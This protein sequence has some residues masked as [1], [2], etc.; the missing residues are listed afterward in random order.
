MEKQDG[1]KITYKS[2]HRRPASEPVQLEQCFV[3]GFRYKFQTAQDGWG[4]VDARQL[5]CRE[6]GNDIIRRWDGWWSERKKEIETKQL[7]SFIA[8]ME[9][10][11]MYWEKLLMEIITAQRA[12][13]PFGL[14]MRVMLSRTPRGNGTWNLSNNGN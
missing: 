7:R 6:Y 3:E 11:E 13:A 14:S 2:K 12:C 5:F 10:M 4:D 8:S 1:T 9:E